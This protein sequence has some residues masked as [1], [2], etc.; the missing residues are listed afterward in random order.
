MLTAALIV[1]AAV[2]LG[3]K[4]FATKLRELAARLPPVSGRQIGAVVLLV[5]AL[6]SYRLSEP[7]PAPAPPPAPPA[8]GLELRGLWRSADDAETVSALCG[9]LADEL[10]LDGLRPEAEQLMRTGVAV[11]ELRRRARELRCRGE[12]LG[13]R[14]PQARDAIAAYLEDKVGTSGGPLTSE[15]RAAW[16]AAFR[17]ISRAAHAR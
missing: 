5:A 6:A 12:S 17:E 14:N 10:E 4:D 9:E 11:D 3:G 2:L 8:A 7:A 1:A 15:S 13:T 16:V